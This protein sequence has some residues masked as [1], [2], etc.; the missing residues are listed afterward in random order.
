M[1]PLRIVGPGSVRG[2]LFDLHAYPGCVLDEDC[3]SSVH[4][5]LLEIPP[6]VEPILSKLDWYEGHV[7]NDPAGSLFVRTTCTV[8]LAD[9]R[10]T[11]AWVYVYNRD[12]SRARLIEPGRYDP[13]T[14]L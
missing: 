13:H 1:N 4:G 12:V 3:D 2:R 11:D 6:P 14:P 8:T 9:G 5:Q 7:A 10:Q